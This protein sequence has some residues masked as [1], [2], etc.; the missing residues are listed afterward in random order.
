MYPSFQRESVI[1][2]GPSQNA[3]LEGYVQFTDERD[4][5]AAI[6]EM[7]G[8]PN[9]IG[10]G[11]L[12][13]SVDDQGKTSTRPNK[14]E[15]E[16]KQSTFVLQL[17]ALPPDVDEEIITQDL[18]EHHLGDYITD[19]FV[20]RKTLSSSMPT[21]VSTDMIEENQ[22]NIVKLKTLFID[23]D[24]FRS[25]PDI[26]IL[27][28]TKDGRVSALILFD[29]PRD[30][31]AAM[32]KYA[33][34]DD[35]DLLKFGAFKLRLVPLLDHN[36]QLHSALAKAIPNKI[37]H[38]IDRIKNDPEFSTIRLIKKVNMKN[39]QEITYISIRGT[40]ILQIYKARTVFDDL[41]KGQIFKFQQPSWVYR[42][43]TYSSTYLCDQCMKIYCIPCKAEYHFG[44]TCEQFQQ[45]EKERKEKALLEKNLGKLPFKKCPKCQ[46]LIEKFA[47]CNAMKCTQCTIAFCWQCLFTDDN[48]V[49]Y[50]FND[51]K[52]SCYNHCFDVDIK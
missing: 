35:P 26:Q 12:R 50:H 22:I 23:P 17:S 51:E 18:Y 31:T 16:K 11:K 48:D 45:L 14:K 19:V 21:N 47:G 49:H 8:K 43:S 36:I 40:N 44:I 13:L 7:N 20:F 39:G 30:V 1:V 52:S 29:D 32:E 46:T 15:N 5:Q 24:R 25:T 4:M 10:P 27:S 28:P 34:P 41:M 42:P 33:A 38:V 37:Q 6:H 3:R 2:L 9:L